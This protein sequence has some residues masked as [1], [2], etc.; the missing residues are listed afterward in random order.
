MKRNNPY[1]GITR[2]TDRH[3][4]LRWR[5][6]RKGIDCYIIG[7]YGSEEFTRQYEAAC[8]G[9]RPDGK[10]DKLARI[11][12]ATFRWLIQSYRQSP[13]FR[14][15]RPVTKRHQNYD[16]EWILQYIADLPFTRFELRHV[17]W[18]MAKKE[19]APSAA[20]NI[21]KRMVALFNYAIRLELMKANPARLS[22]KHQE[23]PDGHY[24]WTD[25]DIE[26][27]RAAY[28]SGTRER[29]AIELALNTGAAR[30]DL[31]RLGWQNIQDGR[32]AYRRGKTDQSTTLPIIPELTEELAHVPTD[33][34]LFILDSKGHPYTPEGLSQW[35]TGRVR[36]AGV[37][38]G[39][40]HG[41]RKAGATRLANAGAT[42][43][44]I[45]AYLA[46]RSTR[47]ATTY[48]KKAD[49]NRLTDSAFAKLQGTNK[50]HILSNLPKKLDK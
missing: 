6:R 19:N 32:I 22:E 42:E 20:N 17:E 21:R 7:E 24:T 11:N 5:F 40:L 2:A 16:F 44:E 48:T 29:L 38:K 49:K 25:A 36:D 33:Q 50:V 23:S 27:F 47:Q 28:P 8:S 13:K 26:R 12:P 15:L 34:M 9:R 3:G 37:A 39:S 35:F 4:K 10:D 31:S 18:L 14:N 30:Q 46:H 41:L 43:N 1:P 45:A